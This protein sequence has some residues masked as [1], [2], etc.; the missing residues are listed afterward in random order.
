M[1]IFIF[2]LLIVPCGIETSFRTEGLSASMDLL[3]VP[4]GIETVIARVEELGKAAFNR[5]LWN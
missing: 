2:I 4:C 1:Y 5:T 3:I